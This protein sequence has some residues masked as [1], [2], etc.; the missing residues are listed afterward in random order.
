MIQSVFNISRFQHLAYDFQNPFIV[1]SYFPELPHQNPVIDRIKV[2][3]NVALNRPYRLIF[4]DA[5][6]IDNIYDVSDCMF[7]RPVRSETVA[8]RVKLCFAYRFQYDFH[9][10]LYDSVK[11]SRYT[12]RTHFSVCF[13]DIFASCRFGFIT[14]KSGLNQCN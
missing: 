2:S 1:D 9:T 10:L 6:C 14:V 7:L 11:H 5:C 12:E 8:V 4:P 3:F 13:G